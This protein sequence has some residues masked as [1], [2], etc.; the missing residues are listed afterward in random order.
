MAR[1]QC[2]VHA[3]TAKWLESPAAELT[4]SACAG[5]QISDGI[6][7]GETSVPSM[8]AT[9]GRRT[10]AHVPAVDAAA[11][12]RKGRR[13]KTDKRSPQPAEEPV[14]R[15]LK[16]EAAAQRVCWGP[17]VHELVGLILRAPPLW[18]KR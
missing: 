3:W 7:W 14:E 8:Y 13:R 4:S 9:S 16:A 1:G 10:A 15:D 17:S 5:C 11:T 2:P 18:Q 6:V 12:A